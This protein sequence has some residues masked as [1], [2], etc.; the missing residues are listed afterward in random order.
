MELGWPHHEVE[1]ITGI[2]EE[3]EGEPPRLDG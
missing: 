3:P 2:Y 1:L